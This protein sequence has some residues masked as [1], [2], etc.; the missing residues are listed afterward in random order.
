MKYV[1]FT[2]FLILLP[3]H[4]QSAEYSEYD[5]LPV[6]QSIDFNKDTV[7]IIT[8]TLVQLKGKRY[9]LLYDRKSKSTKEIGLIEYIELFSN[10]KKQREVS[11]AKIKDRWQHCKPYPESGEY[12]ST[13][14]YLL[15]VQEKQVKTEIPGCHSLTGLPIFLDR[16]W[17]GTYTDGGHGDGYAGGVYIID[18]KTGNTV[19][20]FA[21]HEIIYDVQVDPYEDL[22]WALGWG[23]LFIFNNIP[24][25]DALYLYHDFNREGN[26]I[27][28][29]ATSKTASNPFAVIY[30]FISPENKQAFYQTVKKFTPDQLKSFNLYYFFMHFGKHTSKLAPEFNVL[31]P[32]FV[33]E[34]NISTGI[35]K[36]YWY[37]QLCMLPDYTRYCDN[38]D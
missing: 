11:K 2:L 21:E 10:A 18:I 27:L 38:L 34:A 8:S 19:Y 4:A 24:E 31:G 36:K 1:Y 16:I 25:M 33:K 26:N 14:G 32:L 28:M 22:A 23:A 7:G 9:Y 15:H 3:V 12:V 29:T 30:T 13:G 6:I 37:N 17:V 5:I 35:M 20:Q